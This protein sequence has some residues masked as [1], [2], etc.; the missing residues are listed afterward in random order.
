MKHL[1]KL[2]GK[3]ALSV[4]CAIA[5]ILSAVS[6][7]F[8]VLAAETYSADHYV[9]NA[10][11][12]PALP[13]FAGTM[14][15]LNNVDV[16]FEGDTEATDAAEITWALGGDY[17][18]KLILDSNGVITANLKGNDYKITATAGEKSAILWA[19]VAEETDSAWNLYSI[20]FDAY[21]E[22]YSKLQ[23]QANAYLTEPQTVMVGDKVLTKT[24]QTSDVTP[25]GVVQTT[26]FP[27][28]VVTQRGS[29]GGH[30]LYTWQPYFGG[31]WSYDGTE[32]DYNAATGEG[33]IPDAIK[34]P[35]GWSSYVTRPGSSGV[36]AT[37]KVPYVMPYDLS[38]GLQTNADINAVSASRKG[39]VPFANPYMMDGNGLADIGTYVF[40]YDNGSMNAQRPDAKGYFVFNNEITEAFSDFVVNTNINYNAHNTQ[41][42]EFGVAGLDTS[43]MLQIYARMPITADGAP[44]KDIVIPG[45]ATAYSAKDTV[46]T[47]TD[48]IKFQSIGIN[49]DKAYG[50][51]ARLDYTNVNGQTIHI[52]PYGSNPLSETDSTTKATKWSYLTGLGFTNVSY[53]NTVASNTGV[54]VDLSIKYEG[55]TAT[56]TSKND[57]KNTQIVFDDVL[58]NKGAIA[59]GMNS[60]SSALKPADGVPNHVAQWMNVHQF[61]ID[62]ANDIT[63]ENDGS[64]YPVY[65]KHYY[66]PVVDASLE[67]GYTNIDADEKYFLTLTEAIDYLDGKGGTVWIKGMYEGAGAD[68]EG[69]IDN[70]APITLAG[71]N[72]S[73]DMTVDGEAIKNGILNDT[74]DTSARNWAKGDITF[75]Y[76]YIDTNQKGASK[77]VGDEYVEQDNIDS[78]RTN[79]SFGSGGYTFTFSYGIKNVTTK[80]RDN[81]FLG[82]YPNSS[83]KDS[84]YNIYSGTY[85]SVAPFNTITANACTMNINSTINVYGGTIGTMSVGSFA[86]SGSKPM[87]FTINGDVN[88]NIHGGTITNLN[89]MVQGYRSDIKVTGDIIVRISGGTITNAIANNITQS[90]SNSVHTVSNYTTPVRGNMALIVDASKTSKA[91]L[92]SS[93]TKS[94]FSDFVLAENKYYIGIINNYTGANCYF[95]TQTYA[96]GTSVL[97]RF[98]Y[99]ITVKNG[100]AQPVFVRTDANDPSTSYLQGF[101]I[102]PN[103]A[104]KIPAI[105]G[106]KL[107]PTGKKTADG[108][109]LY[110]LSAYKSSRDD[111]SDD[112]TITAIT[113]IDERTP[114]VSTDESFTP[115]AELYTKVATIDEAIA[116]LG[117]EGGTIYIKGAYTITNMQTEFALSKGVKAGK[118]LVI[119]G[120]GD[121]AEGNTLNL[122][123][124]SSSVNLAAAWMYCDVTFE[125]LT[126]VR[127]KSA[128]NTGFNS[129][130]YV[131]TL[132]EGLE[133]SVT[134]FTIGQVVAGKTNNIVVNSGNW[135]QLISTC[136]NTSQFGT[137]GTNVN[138][139]LNGGYYSLGGDSAGA[140]FVGG[141]DNGNYYDKVTEVR[142]GKSSYINGD[143]TWTINQGV[144]FENNKLRT[145]GR[146]YAAFACYGTLSV[147]VNGGNLQQVEMHV[148]KENSTNSVDGPMVS[149]YNNM[150]VTID[151]RYTKTIINSQ[152]TSVDKTA[153][154]N[155][156]KYIAIGNYVTENIIA[157]VAHG[158]DY[159]VNV[160][161]GEAHPVFNGT[162]ADAVFAGFTITP[163]AENAGKLVVVNG[164]DVLTAVDGMYDLSAYEDMGILNI[165]FVDAREME[166][167]EEA[168]EDEEVLTEY[169]NGVI[170]EKEGYL[171]AGYYAEG[172]DKAMTAEQFAAADSVVVKFIPKAVLG[173]AWQIAKGEGNTANLR[174]IS[175]VD[176]LQYQKVIFTLKV[177]GRDDM[178]MESYTVYESIKG[179]VNGQEIVYD[180]PTIFSSVSGYFMTHIVSGIPDTFHG[181]ELKVTANLVTKDGKIIPGD[182]VPITIKKADDYEAI[183]GT[184]NQ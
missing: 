174:L 81:I 46:V 20:D 133:A 9:V 44:T 178:V 82:V 115:D 13:L 31:T 87:Y 119:A 100:E 74:A 96:D 33:T 10:N 61:S 79:F 111:S 144:E 121:T 75:Q 117:A 49:A 156:K 128:E 95:N 142:T 155:G 159:A 7:S 76:M 90:A 134:N 64:E 37:Y 12:S 160:Y 21:T 29:S 2:F 40:N 48:A 36:S 73:A 62:L 148:G 140:N 5:I 166:T 127:S 85:T 165:T 16:I 35:S 88:Y 4:V 54:N 69:T 22:A 106:V 91:I 6:V 172:S 104:G 11:T 52:M 32:F 152:L 83:A 8:G 42:P 132:G 129:N 56:L 170:P 18:K 173:V 110:D 23:F 89:L 60:I 59:F 123:T 78:N 86:N 102:V 168:V 143:I 57:S 124:A 131:L 65:V 63:A 41:Q 114:V 51:I 26:L 151:A 55:T 177:E 38:A 3:K 147:N 130:G 126:M 77:K 43:K 171:F 107:E 50:Y 45:S 105:N 99:K 118:K 154:N 25:D 120:F 179:N 125:N 93:G 163:S 137:A 84:N 68:F 28:Y 80:Q 24:F 175:S 169:K 122:G 141:Y 98:D 183:F 27:N 135:N 101:T 15:D 138:Y 17:G 58:E 164:T 181:A 70:R 112:K 136:V 108:L 158:L 97:N 145:T 167:T 157:N 180:D 150:V 103:E 161:G 113:F 39:I 1:T 72:N 146:G 53:A 182:E 30:P 67:E 116:S 47:N 94:D 14:V 34:F 139:V 153:E 176:S 109:D 71:Y 162:G 92:G 149:R 184:A 19:V 66:Q